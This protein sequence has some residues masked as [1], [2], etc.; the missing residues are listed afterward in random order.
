MSATTAPAGWYAD[1]YRQGGL[2]YFDG[3][4]WTEHTAAPPPTASGSTVVAHPGAAVPPPDDGVLRWLVP[5][6]RTGLSIAA[7]YA[8]I[9]ALLCF[10]A[11]PLSLVLGL[12]ALRQLRDPTLRGRGRAW[13]A[14]VVGG[15]GTA[16]LAVFAYYATTGG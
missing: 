13:F 3:L 14:T 10:Y 7:G 6:G 15:L 5:V 16:G 12:L 2:R 11:A 1:P 8:G 4:A 9:A